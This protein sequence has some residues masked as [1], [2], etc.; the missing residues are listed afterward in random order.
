MEMRGEE[1]VSVK[2]ECWTID[3][4]QRSAIEPE[5]IKS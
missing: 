2:K 3:L 4:M 5:F 1:L